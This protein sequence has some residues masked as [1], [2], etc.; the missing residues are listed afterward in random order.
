MAATDR[1]TIKAVTMLG[2]AVVETASLPLTSESAKFEKKRKSSVPK[3]NRKR[4]RSAYVSK[5]AKWLKER[6]RRRSSG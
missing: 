4:R 5:N 6:S 1:P 2:H 3:L